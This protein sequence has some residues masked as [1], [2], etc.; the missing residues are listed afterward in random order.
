[1]KQKIYLAFQNKI[2]KMREESGQIPECVDNHDAFFPDEF[3]DTETRHYAVKTAKEIC[4]RCPL[5]AD[6]ANYAVQANEP[7]GIYGGTTPAE[8][9]VIVENIKRLKRRQRN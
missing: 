4:N 3:T 5:I 9:A 7:F 1:M 6:C 2:R 8:R